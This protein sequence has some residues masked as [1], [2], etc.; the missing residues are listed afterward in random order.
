MMNFNIL[1]WDI[2]GSIK[3]VGNN[4]KVE[5]YLNDV[6]K[7]NISNKMKLFFKTPSFKRKRLLMNILFFSNK[8][9]IVTNILSAPPTF[10]VSIICSTFK[11]L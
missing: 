11:S 10:N 6:N 9:L 4:D 1:E 8:L 5:F 7:E 2:D 3:I